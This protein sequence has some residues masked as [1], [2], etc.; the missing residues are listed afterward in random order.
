MNLHHNVNNI[1]GKTVFFFWATLLGLGVILHPN[2][3]NKIRG[4]TDFFGDY[5]LCLRMIFHT[6]A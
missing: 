3:H 4:K 5:P 2:I 6:N 1:F